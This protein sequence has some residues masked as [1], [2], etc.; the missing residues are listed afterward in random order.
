MT[1][2]L[3][4]AGAGCGGQNL[5]PG[6]SGGASGSGGGAGTKG[7]VPDLACVN[8]VCAGPNAPAVDCGD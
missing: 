2:A 1:A 5:G 6:G 4:I 7:G 8:G 3:A